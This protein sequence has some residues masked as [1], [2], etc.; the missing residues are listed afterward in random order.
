MLPLVAV[1]VIGWV[2]TGVEEATFMVI[3]EVP[4]PLMEGGPKVTLTPLGSPE[5]ARAIDELNPPETAVVIVEVPLPPCAT[6][7]VV[8]EAETVKPVS[9]A[10]ARA[11]I[12]LAP[13]GLPH[14]VTR[15]YPFTAG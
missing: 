6:E 4:A 13:L 8:G 9:G 5:A 12:R 11:L 15:S 1:M 10:P 14:P 3:V 7:T 2:P